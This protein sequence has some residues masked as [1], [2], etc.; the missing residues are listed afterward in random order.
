[1]WC[2]VVWQFATISLESQRT[3]TGLHG[4]TS[5]TIILF[6]AQSLC[7]TQNVGSCLHSVRTSY[8]RANNQCNVYS[9][10]CILPSVMIEEDNRLTLSSPLSLL[11]KEAQRYYFL[12]WIF[13]QLLHAAFQIHSFIFKTTLLDF[14]HHVSL[15]KSLHFGHWYAFCF[16]AKRTKQ[17]TYSVGSCGTATLKPNS[18]KV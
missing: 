15:L 9:C 17:R 7:Q 8:N 16:W 12:Q 5:Q 13:Y 10:C 1:M 4:V 11:I 14:P 2:H 6:K 3:S 18:K